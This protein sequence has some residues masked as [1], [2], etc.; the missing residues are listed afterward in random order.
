MTRA[1]AEAVIA[2]YAAG[3]DVPGNKLVEALK[4]IPTE[5]GIAWCPGGPL[6]GDRVGGTI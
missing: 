4:V 6:Y 2:A 5:F 1:H 3:S